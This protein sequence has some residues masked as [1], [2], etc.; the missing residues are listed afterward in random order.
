M[1][2]HFL[3]CDNTNV[4]CTYARVGHD[5]HA[6]L[7]LVCVSGHLEPGLDTVHTVVFSVSNAQHVGA[8]EQ[9]EAVRDTP[10]AI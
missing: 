5:L 4:A 9:C 3:Y 7:V 2:A 8:L 10:V 1:L 6:G